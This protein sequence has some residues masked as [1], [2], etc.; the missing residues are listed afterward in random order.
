MDDSISTLRRQ[1]GAPGSRPTQRR[2]AKRRVQPHHR[3]RRLVALVVFAVLV[4]VIGIAVG[5][6]GSSTP[7]VAHAS[8]HVSTGYFTRIGTLAGTGAGSFAASEKA[9]E[10]AAVTKTLAYTPYVVVAGAQHSELALTFDDGPG[11]VHAPVRL[12]AQA[13]PRPGDF[14]RGRDR[15][16]GLPRWHDR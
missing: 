2:S 12:L 15:R 5:S 4:L 16:V 9:A 11:P 3:R 8:A 14:L 6:G 7:P 13:V 1:P 10:N